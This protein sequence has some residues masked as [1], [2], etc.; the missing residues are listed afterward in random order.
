MGTTAVGLLIAI[1]ALWGHGYL[2]NR[3]EALDTEMRVASLELAN[4]LS[5]LQPAKSFDA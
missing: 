5:L 3:L 4:S 2:C 1:F